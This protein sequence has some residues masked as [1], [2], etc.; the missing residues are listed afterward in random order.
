MLLA[1]LF[2]CFTGKVGFLKFISLIHSFRESFV[3]FI[4]ICVCKNCLFYLLIYMSKY[5]YI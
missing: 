4:Y 5:F 1:Q 2:K 3:K